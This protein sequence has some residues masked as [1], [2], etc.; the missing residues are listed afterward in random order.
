MSLRHLPMSRIVSGLTRDVSIAIALPSQRER[1]LTSC[2]VKPM[3]GP[4]VRNTAQMAALILVL[5][6]VTHLYLWRTD[7]RG[8]VPVAPRH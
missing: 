3:V 5:W 8:V 1:A 6:I 4:A 2:G 7:A